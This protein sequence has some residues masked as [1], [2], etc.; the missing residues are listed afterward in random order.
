MRLVENFIIPHRT[1]GRVNSVCNNSALVQNM[2]LEITKLYNLV[3]EMCHI[4]FY[5]NV[6]FNLI[7]FI[8]QMSLIECSRTD[9]EKLHILSV[10]PYAKI[11]SQI[12]NNKVDV[13]QNNWHSSVRSVE[14][15]WE[16][17]YIV[18]HFC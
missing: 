10:L 6:P 15:K 8:L 7:V 17:H 9:Q 3:I 11:L 14:G 13:F 1:K 18:L 12:S 2:Q 4:C 5:F 16:L